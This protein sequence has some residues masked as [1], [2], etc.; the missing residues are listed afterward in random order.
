[1]ISEDCIKLATSD[2][3]NVALWKIFNSESDTGKNIFLT[4]G[5][6]SDKKI[7]SGISNY[8][9]NLGYTC[10]IMEWRNH[11]KSSITKEN[12]NFETIA[13][14]DMV[15]V[16]NYLFGTLKINSMNCITHSG[17]GICLTMFL[18]KN[19]QY[20][21]KLNSITMFSCQSFGAAH[22]FENYIKIL[23]GK[24]IS[25]ILGHTPGKFVGLGKCNESYAIMK[26][27]FDWNLYRNFKGENNFDYLETMKSIT[28]P[29][30]SICS[31]GDRFI[32]PKEGCVKFLNAFENFQNKLLFC[33]TKNGFTEN[34]NHAS[35][36]FSKNSAN[37]I[38]PI[39]LEW[40]ENCKNANHE[41][42][43]NLYNGNHI[44]K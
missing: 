6:F 33:S 19:Q 13:K 36:I 16:F 43:D 20:I 31:E 10:W 17:G 21:S 27:W 24:L 4:H 14:Y 11:G 8:F 2:N 37:E 5:T 35:V 18:I 40:I 26:Q 7:C 29:I 30:L 9:A 23:S 22:S 28:T 15:S 38:W 32:S 25:F 44:I 1:M 39:V 42:F 41:P 3:E 34:Y 12:F